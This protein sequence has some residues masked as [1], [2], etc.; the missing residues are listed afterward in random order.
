MD[1][2]SATIAE[3]LQECLDRGMQ[4]PFIVCSASP[5]GSVLAL[6]FSAA[7]DDPDILAEHYEPAGFEFPMT[8]MIL[9]RTNDKALVTL[10]ATGRTWH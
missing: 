4:L 6:R 10:D 5:N 9:D 8:I 1:D 3:V 7:G 2:L